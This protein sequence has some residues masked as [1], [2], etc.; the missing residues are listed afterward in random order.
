VFVEGVV[1]IGS[2]LLAF[3]MQAWWDARQE[4]FALTAHLSALA[5]DVTEARSDV[6]LSQGRRERR[7]DTIHSLL[8]VITG[9]EDPPP[10]DTLTDWL[11]TLWGASSPLLP[12]AALDD[13]RASGVLASIESQELRRA[14]FDYARASEAVIVGEERVIRSWEEGLRPYLTTHT[15]ALPQVQAGRFL[16]LE[17]YEPVFDA[18][19]EALLNDRVFQNLLLIRLNRTVGAYFDAATVISLLDRIATLLELESR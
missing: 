6:M 17:E 13:L 9:A 19:I 15:D 5:E 14:L 10:R 11:G 8:R 7:M 16:D 2:I 1:I 3:G 12:F 4:R 18:D